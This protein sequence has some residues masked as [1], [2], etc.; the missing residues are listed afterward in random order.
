MRRADPLFLFRLK[1]SRG[2]A[3]FPRV[4]TERSTATRQRFGS[5]PTG[6]VETPAQGGFPQEWAQSQQIEAAKGLKIGPARPNRSGNWI[7][8]TLAHRVLVQAPHRP[9][10]PGLLIAKGAVL[11]PTIVSN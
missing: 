9:L 8:G 10:H 6:G 1:G 2:K 3:P 4:L 11:S 7:F 5:L